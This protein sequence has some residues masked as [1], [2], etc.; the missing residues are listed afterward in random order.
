MSKK[1]I[2]AKSTSNLKTSAAI[3]S[4][5][6][7]AAN[8]VWE[9]TGNWE[10]KKNLSIK[11]WFFCRSKSRKNSNTKNPQIF[12]TSKEYETMIKVRQ[13]TRLHTIQIEST[14]DVCFFLVV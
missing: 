3:G 2:E 1:V 14:L 5:E 8:S 7:V 11:V 13:W 12:Q 4:S 10:K 9:K 6:K